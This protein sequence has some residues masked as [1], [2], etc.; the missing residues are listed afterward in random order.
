MRINIFSPVILFKNKIKTPT[1]CNLKLLLESPQYL[2]ICRLRSKNSTGKPERE[3]REKKKRRPRLHLTASGNLKFRYNLQKHL[4]LGTH[5][6]GDN[7][8]NAQLK[9][10]RFSSRQ[11]K[12]RVREGVTAD[13]APPKRAKSVHEDRNGALQPSLNPLFQNARHSVVRKHFR[14]QFRVLSCPLT[15]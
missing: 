3:D 14:L 10:H 11:G 15:K 5:G 2:Y 7:Y 13:L 9:R 1:E 8:G 4:F 6:K 12:A